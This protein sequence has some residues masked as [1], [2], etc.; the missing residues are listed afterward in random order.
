ME[1]A[2]APINKDKMTG[3]INR[4][5]LFIKIGRM[6]IGAYGLNE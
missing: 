2:E 3:D 6:E 4:T 5:K 1:T